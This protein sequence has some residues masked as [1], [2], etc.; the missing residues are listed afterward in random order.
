MDGLPV[1]FTAPALLGLGI[2]NTI[3]KHPAMR[4]NRKTDDRSAN[5]DHCGGNPKRNRVNLNGHVPVAFCQ[6]SIPSGQILAQRRPALVVALVHC[7]PVGTRPYF[8]PAP[9]RRLRHP[10]SAESSQPARGRCAPA[11]RAS[12]GFATALA[13]RSRR[14]RSPSDSPVSRLV[15]L[16]SARL[17][18]MFPGRRVRG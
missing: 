7:F 11:R 4:L 9:H 1:A 5:A 10:L 6:F 2:Q 16:L 13:T 12:G 8:P 17:P 14:P 18:C 15:D 3:P